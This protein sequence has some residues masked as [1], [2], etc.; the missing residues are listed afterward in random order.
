ML[1]YCLSH[2]HSSS[3]TAPEMDF[4]YQWVTNGIGFVESVAQWRTPLLDYYFLFA[5]FLGQE[6]FFLIAPPAIYWLYNK[7][8][9]RRLVYLLMLGAWSNEAFKNLLRLPR[10]PAPIAL[11]DE[12]GYGLP[13]GHAQIGVMLWGYAGWSLRQTVRWAPALVLWTIAS[14]SFSRL[15]L[16]VHYPAD[17][18]A[19]LLLGALFLWIALRVE[20]RLSDWYGRLNTRQIVAFAALL[21]VLSLV[22]LPTGGG[23]WP[24]ET[25]ATEAGLVF[26][27]LVGLEA[28]KR[29]VGF[30]VAG[31]GSR[32]LLRYLL[33]L[34]VIVAVWGGLRAVFGLIDAGHLIDSGLRII[35]YALLGF[36]V[37][38]WLPAL[39][40]RIGLAQKQQ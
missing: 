35:R 37:T 8:L 17:V 14:I 38:W 2:S 30:S 27:V 18:L 4:L 26:G 28:E 20:S 29:R 12:V 23:P 19:G 31:S 40:V 33:G 11:V 15:Y 6:E 5:A 25:G 16:G 10:P 34:V 39:F 1:Y 36:T 32:K 3:N 9:G 7:Q 24:F 21:S 13:S 22:L